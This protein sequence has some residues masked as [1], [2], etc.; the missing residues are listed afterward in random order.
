MRFEGS[1][2]RLPTGCLLS[3]LALAWISVAPAAGQSL[4]VAGQVSPA[5]LANE[6]ISSILVPQTAEGPSR[7]LSMDEAVALALEQNLDIQVERLNPQIQ[8]LSIAQARA[9]WTPVFSTTFQTN[10]ST[11]PS[12][13]AIA[14][15]ETQIVNDTTQNNFGVNQALPWFGGSYQLSWDASRA[16]TTNIFS[17]FDP[18]FRSGLDF[19]F[20][21][22]LLR[23]FRIDNT[24]QQLRVSTTNRE[25]SDIQLRE[26]VS[27]TVRNVKN[28]YWNLVY[29]RFSLAV[30]EEAL[31]LAQESLR[32]NRTRVEVGTMAPIDIVEAEAEVAR[33]EEA[34]ILAEA[35]IEQAEDQLRALIFDPATPDF[36]N[37][38][39]ETT[40]EPVL[41]TQP[42]DI[43]SA[44]QAALTR[45]TDLERTKKNL[46]NNETDIDF[47]RNQT[48]PDLNL[49]FDYNLAGLGGTR[50]ARGA[51]FPGPIIGT[52]ETSFGNVLGQLFGND[53]PAWTFS[54]T[55]GYPIGTSQAEA[56]L[57]QARLQYTQAQTQMKSVEL[58]IA[59]QVRAVGRQ[60]NT[61]LKRVEA[62]RAAR[63]L[64][65]R[66]LEAEQ[67]KFEVGMSTSFLVFQAQ[68]DLSQARDAELRAILDYNQAIVDFEAVQES[69]LSGGG[70]GSVTVTTGAPQ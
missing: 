25:I 45:R 64:S 22:P 50:F 35:A 13:S 11:T 27:Q 14:G 24:R 19:T 51:G 39:I 18:V 47:F 40:E 41:Q 52:S 7:R 5:T 69:A 65:Q 10:S 57:A 43:D 6:P 31:E 34:V 32:N 48:L 26:T 36:W 16:T 56:S 28:A 44:I 23:N 1:T 58:Q 29:S 60:V 53:F 67:Q 42:I 37:L 66:R 17:N 55:I 68:R 12:N 3:A 4:P 38:E 46:E 20:V 30:Q 61:N 8:D 33:N 59:T 70:G 9:N 63:E 62:T 2:K 15:G 49:Q 54:L 21:Q